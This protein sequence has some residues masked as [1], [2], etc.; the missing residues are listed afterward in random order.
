MTEPSYTVHYCPPEYPA[1][2]NPASCKHEPQFVVQ[3]DVKINW[4]SRGKNKI[5]IDHA[6]C[7]ACGKPMPSTIGGNVLVDLQ[8]LWERF[9][10]QAQFGARIITLRNKWAKIATYLFDENGWNGRHERIAR[11][12][13][14]KLTMKLTIERLSAEHRM[15]RISFDPSYL[16]A[17]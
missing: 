3:A 8:M 4:N 9:G 14:P 11:L 15:G 17:A 13:D 5:E 7:F 12:I 16:R 10:W 6:V 1:R 2:C